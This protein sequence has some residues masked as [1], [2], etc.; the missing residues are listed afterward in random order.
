MKILFIT[1]SAPFGVGESFVVSEANAIASLGHKVILVPTLIRKNS[2]NNFKLEES[3][4]LLAEPLIS[5][6]IFFT[7]LLFFAFN[8]KKGFYL[9]DLVTDRNLVN[10]LKNYLIIPKAV[11]LA[12]H[13]KLTPVDHIHAHWLTTSATLAMLVS[14]LTGISW[15]ATAH[16]GDI[17]ANN[18]LQEKFIRAGFIRFISKSGKVL[19]S[20]RIHNLEYNAKI[21]YLGINL[22]NVSSPNPDLRT[23]SPN[24]FHFVCPANLVPVK[25]HDVLI[26]SISKMKFKNKIKL[27]IVGEG[28]LRNKLELK[29]KQLGLGENIKF[30]GHIPHSKLLDWYKMGNVDAVILPSLDLGNGNHEGIPVSL[31]EAMAFSIP[32]I[33]TRTGGIP[34]LLEDDYEQFGYL[35]D[36]NDSNQLTMMLD[37]LVKNPESITKIAKLG[38]QRVMGDF[39]Q[40]KTLDQLI[41]LIKNEGST[42]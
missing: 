13:I 26:E 6:K 3:I 11:W 38:Y 28:K 31:M 29:V 41:T 36:A 30:L 1:S 7:S 21:I 22:E 34:E 8:I 32:V 42:L 9:F 25:G 20:E 24:Y 12:N 27:S 10:T 23:F 35:V 16:R 5:L 15:S 40:S 39:N 14:G 17:V 18:L 4:K 19:A 37:S 33:S 2:P